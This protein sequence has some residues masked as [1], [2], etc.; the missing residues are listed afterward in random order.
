MAYHPYKQKKSLTDTISVRDKKG[1][2]P[3]LSAIAVPSALG[4]LNFSVRDGKRWYPPAMATH[5]PY[6]RH[7]CRYPISF[8]S[9][10]TVRTVTMTAV[11]MQFLFFDLRIHTSSGSFRVISTTR[12]HASPHFHLWPIDVVVFYVPQG[13]FISETASRL[14]AFSAYPCRT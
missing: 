1:R 13:R 14:D 7:P 3:T 11:G 5:N 8:C 4:G 6:G 12:L 9:F 2:R 10:V